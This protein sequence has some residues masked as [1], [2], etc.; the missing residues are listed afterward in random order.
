MLLDLGN[1]EARSVGS[2]A[3][4]KHLKAVG[5]A[6]L[7]PPVPKLFQHAH[8][9]SLTSMQASRAVGISDCIQKPKTQCGP[10]G[11]S[12]AVSRRAMLPPETTL[13]LSRAGKKVQL[14]LRPWA[15]DFLWCMP[16]H[17]PNSG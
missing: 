4:I 1:Q 17:Y 6:C 7:L 15:S 2:A 16:G 10:G 12:T 9:C 8:I 11:C 13:S 3:I 14:S 5:F